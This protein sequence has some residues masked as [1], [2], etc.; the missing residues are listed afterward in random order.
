MYVFITQ[1]Q[2]YSTY[3][4]QNTNTFQKFILFENC[5]TKKL[6][7]NEGEEGIHFF[8]STS[9]VLN[10]KFMEFFR[11]SMNDI[12]HSWSSFTTQFQKKD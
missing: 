4:F 12:L 11:N 8:N 6:I 5:L 1:K 10:T 3:Y 7:K 2:T 9:K